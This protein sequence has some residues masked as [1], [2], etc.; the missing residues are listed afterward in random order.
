MEEFYSRSLTVNGYYYLIDAIYYI[1]GLISVLSMLPLTI[2]N[3][4]NE[5]SM[6]NVSSNLA[7]TEVYAIYGFW[8]GVALGSIFAL[9][10]S[11][12]LISFVLLELLLFSQFDFLVL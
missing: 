11:L 10:C 7:S 6:F 12:G 5:S 8:L 3:S 9:L 2:N 4:T 1:R